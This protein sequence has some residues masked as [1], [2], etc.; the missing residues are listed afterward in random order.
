MKHD[1]L[2]SRHDRFLAFVLEAGANRSRP[3]VDVAL[4]E[5]L[6]RDFE[7]ECGDA[8]PE[9]QRVARDAI[10]RATGVRDEG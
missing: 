4:Y 8:T 1:D 7:R 6:M 10:K 3:G 2:P 5:R 9:E